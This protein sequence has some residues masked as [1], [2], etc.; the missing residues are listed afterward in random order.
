MAP[1]NEERANVTIIQVIPFDSR[2]KY[3]ASVIRQFGSYRMYVKGDPEILLGK[4]TQVVVDTT[5]P[6]R[7]MN[8]TQGN[9]NSISST[10]DKYAVK[11]LHTIGIAYRDFRC[12]PPPGVET[13][14]GNFENVFKEMVFVGVVGIR[15]PVR[16]G[17]NEAVAQFQ[18]A[19]VYVRMVAGDNVKTA[20][21]VAQEC[22]IY[23]Q[24]GCVMEGPEFRRLSSTQMDQVIPQLQVLARSSPEDKIILV[25]RLKE[26]GKTVAVTGDGTNDGLALNTA[27]V[28]FSMGITGTEIAKEASSIVLMDDNFASIVKA[29]QWGRIIN[30]AVKKFYRLAFTVLAN[31]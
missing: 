27:D 28:D 17:V 16:P 21:A 6:L 9:C 15:D 5:K 20:V 14:A 11:S 3:M 18:H 4:C 7:V 31:G 19:G 13:T 8:L 2:R 12:W 10:I 29:L 23:T 26:L 1:L 30:D 24:G 22:G 25:K